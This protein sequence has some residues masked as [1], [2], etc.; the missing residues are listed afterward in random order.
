MEEPTAP[1]NPDPAPAAPAPLK[2]LTPGTPEYIDE[3]F[4]YHAPSEEQIAHY[5]A[6]RASAKAFAETLA[7]H[8]PPSADRSDAFRK[9]REVVMT[10]NSS[11]ALSGRA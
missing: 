4:Q 9:L 7:V 6:I 10:A 2:K 11:V 5:A 3:V 8:C 1:S